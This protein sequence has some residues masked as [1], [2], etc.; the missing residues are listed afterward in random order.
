MDYYEEKYRHSSGSYKACFYCL[1]GIVILLVVA[2]FCSC[3]TKRTITETVIR[4]SVN[5]RDSIRVKDSTIITN[6][7][8]I[9]D[10]VRIKDSTVV[11]VDSAGNVKQIKE[12]H[13][14]KVHH[15]EKDSTAFYKNLLNDVVH[16][17]V[18]ERDSKKEAKVATAPSTP[19]WKKFLKW[20]GI[21]FWGIVFV[22]IVLYLPNIRNIRLF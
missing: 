21:A 6:K 16:E 13:S 3:T 17:L 11:V 2:S 20:S 7:V 9:R 4:D 1:I 15:A 18:K 8:V 10:S 14:E 22:V 5:I 12:Y 19:A